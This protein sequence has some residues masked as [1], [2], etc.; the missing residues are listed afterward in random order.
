MMKDSL[1][2]AYYRVSSKR[3]GDRWS[4]TAQQEAVHKEAKRRRYSIE[5]ECQD[6]KSGSSMDRSGLRKILAEVETGRYNYLL[7]WRLNRLT[8]SLADFLK[9]TAICQDNDT[10]II[11]LMEPV[12]VNAI[13]RLQQQIYVMFGEWQL[14]VLKDNQKMAY[15]QKMNEG[16]LL[17]SSV[18]LGYEYVAGQ[19]KVVAADSKIVQYLYD[20]Y[21]LGRLGYR[22]LAERIHQKFDYALTPNGVANILRNRVYTGVLEN[23]Y[24]R[25]ANLFPRIIEDRQFEHVQRIRQSRQVIKKHASN[26]CL[27]HK[28][29]CPVCGG[30]LTP[31]HMIRGHRQYDYWYCARSACS[32]IRIN[33]VDLLAQ[34][35]AHLMT[36]IDNHLRERLLEE[37]RQRSV[38]KPMVSQMID[39]TKLFQQFET[40]ELSSEELAEQLAQ[41]KVIKQRVTTNQIAQKQLELKVR[42]L[43]SKLDQTGT[44]GLLAGLDIDHIEIN[45]LKQV[46]GLFIQP[47]PKINLFKLGDVD[48]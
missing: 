24:G 47:V 45:G 12:Q 13:G 37:I 48:T 38:M 14:G 42:G 20:E 39:Q 3:Q 44:E 15:Q 26:E 8:R 41:A 7:V 43:L 31:T 32:G 2:L 1:A 27:Q 40:G 21:S 34:L 36:L 9:M 25:Q 29:V 17:S 19:V 16:K 35:D 23:Q 18:P 30:S 10:Q 5:I 22:K 33:E 4:L 11:S 28:V 46:T 6:V